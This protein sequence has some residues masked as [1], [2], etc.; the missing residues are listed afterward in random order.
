VSY[1][2]PPALALCG[3]L[4][5][6]AGAAAGAPKAEQ[7]GSGIGLARIAAVGDGL[8]VTSAPGERN[9]LYVAQQSGRIIVLERGRRLARPF[10]NVAARVSSGGEQG[11]LGLAFHPDYARNG[12]FY[13]NLTDR[14]GATRVV[15]YR[16]SGNPNRA[17]P[18]SA[19]QL[20][21]IPQFAANH[22]GGALKF[23]PD[24]FLY[25][26]TGDGG[27]G[28]DTEGN[29]Q[30]RGSL[31]GA[32]LRIDVD[33]RAGGRRYAVPASNPFRGSRAPEVHHYGLRNPWRFS[34]D[35]T[36]GDIWIGDVGQGAVEEI[37]FRRAGAPG[38]ANFGWNAFEGRA[39]FPGGGPIAGG[40]AHVPPVA[41]YGHAKG[42]SVTG[43]YVYRG[44][45]VPALRGKYVYSD[46]CTGRT[47]AMRAG[48]NPGAVREITGRLNVRLGNVTSFG[49]G[50]N[51]DLYV[52]ANGALFRFV[53]R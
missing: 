20:L 18:G 32:I 21:R 26:A 9:R 38:G 28:G 33:R 17:N 6:G 45:R 12:R 1:L 42:C 34:F 2:R 36:R 14:A 13:V 44:T 5:L 47:W 8:D 11:L 31:L 22:N 23:G 27:G 46:F 25:I 30:N 3:L 4:A 50:G 53:R 24:G 39:R 16:R 7:Q 35:R 15:E 29:G 52:I 40:R 19:R 48:P 37:D 10:L 49:E 51:G 41:Q 43:G